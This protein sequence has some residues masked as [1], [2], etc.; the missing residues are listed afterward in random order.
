M[1]H[2]ITVRT[3]EINQI[4]VVLSFLPKNINQK[5]VE[6]LWLLVLFYESFFNLHISCFRVYRQ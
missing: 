3:K 2:M 5:V 4:H 6:Q 1:L